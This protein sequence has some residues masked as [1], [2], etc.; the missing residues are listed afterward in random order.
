MVWRRPLLAQPDGGYVVGSETALV[1]MASPLDLLL[2]QD[3]SAARALSLASALGLDW[4]ARKLRAGR[5]LREAEVVATVRTALD[6]RASDL[7][8]LREAAE[9]L[10]NVNLGDDRD[11]EAPAMTVEEWITQRDRA[12]VLMA[13]LL[14]GVRLRPAI[15]DRVIDAHES[16]DPLSLAAVEALL[17][18]RRRRPL[19]ECRHCGLPFVQAERVDQFYCRRPAPGDPRRTCAVLGPQRQYA[20]N[21]GALEAAYRREYKRLDNRVRR[22]RF[23]R[24]ALD[25]WRQRARALLEAA[26]RRSWSEDRLV[27]ELRS[28]EPKEEH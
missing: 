6:E 2:G 11:H 22:G 8:D 4:T 25:Q 20:Q 19:W 15:S 10:L 23:T 24:A 27:K 12:M 17:M 21:I 14:E 18:G 13:R 3:G 16:D 9:T 7:Q 28:I 26:Q 5:R 1:A